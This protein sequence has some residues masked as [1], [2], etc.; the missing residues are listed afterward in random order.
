MALGAMGRGLGSPRSPGSVIEGTILFFPSNYDDPKRK[1]IVS[2]EKGIRS[3][4][5]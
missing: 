2:I 3:K 1:G 5:K 4:M